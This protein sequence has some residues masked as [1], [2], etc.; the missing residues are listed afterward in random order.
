[1]VKLDLRKE[2]KSIYHAP[3]RRVVLVDVP[4]MNFLMVDGEG[5]PNRVERFQEAVEALYSLSYTLKF[6]I[7]KSRIGIDYKV[8]PLEGLWWMDDM[9][10]FSMDNKDQ[11]KWTLL[12]MQPDL[13]TAQLY[14]EA[15]E[16]VQNKKNLSILPAVRLTSYHEGLAAQTMHVGPYS[17]EAATIAVVHQ[18]AQESGYALAGKHHEIYLGDPR[19]SAPEKLKT[20]IRQPVVKK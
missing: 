12:M 10:E 7:K 20:I 14:D 6:M 4:V 18:Y 11:W 9:C 15:W 1:M 5:D 2:L 19:K 8:M 16:R 13:V 3:T 17:E